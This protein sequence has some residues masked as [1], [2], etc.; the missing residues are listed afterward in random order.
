[1][2]EPAALFVVVEPL[3]ACTDDKASKTRNPWI[4]DMLE[5]SEKMK[6]WTNKG[7]EFDDI[8]KFFRKTKKIIIS[9][10]LSC[11][12]REQ[13]LKKL[14][15]LDIDIEFNN[16]IVIILKTFFKKSYSGET[17]FL[18]RTGYKK[19]LRAD[20]VFKFTDFLEKYLSIFAVYAKEKIYLDATSLFCTT[21]CSLNC[22]DCGIFTPYNKNKKHFC[23]EDL[24]KDV[25]IY[26]SCVD[27][28]KTLGISG[29]EPFLHP[30]LIELIE[31]IGKLHGDKIEEL[32]IAT[33]GTIIPSDEL[34]ETLKK[35]KVEVDV[36][37]YRETVPRLEETFP[38]VV[39][40]LIKYTVVHT[41]KHDF[42][43]LLPT[44]Q[45]MQN[46]SE[47]ELMKKYF[48]CDHNCKVLADGKFYKC[49]FVKCA[50]DAGL[51]TENENDFYD[52]AKFTK[53]R[54]ETRQDKTRQDKT[55]QD[56]QDIN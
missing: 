14:S 55:R 38:A 40:K 10:R 7:H 22:K 21:V 20:Y 31:Y 6:K 41:I 33:N 39:D 53:D 2:S 8:G 1:M 48:Y 43:K 49:G 56:K 51:L 28:V 5:K 16:P 47:K 15:F 19:I 37:D 42:Y 23:V 17:I 30:D 13:I 46:C 9:S 36:T 35:Y 52:L 44:K 34:C 32:H 26:F 3:Y 50:V 54:T 25:D 11:D 27:R 4:E 24:K 29:G 18:L 45:S 12:R